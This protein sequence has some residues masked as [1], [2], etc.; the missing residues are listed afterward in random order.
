MGQSAVASGVKFRPG[1]SGEKVA[2]GLVWRF[3]IFDCV[4]DNLA[5]FE[6]SF[7]NSGSFLDVGSHR[8][9]VAKPF[10]E[11]V[12]NVFDSLCEGGSSCGES[13]NLGT[14]VEVMALGE[15]EG[16]DLPCPERP[17]LERLPPQEQ[18][19]PLPER[20]APDVSVVDLRAPLGR[21]IDPA[22]VAEALERTRLVLL[23]KVA[24]DE[25]N[26]CRTSTTLSEFYDVHGDAPTELSRDLCRSFATVVPG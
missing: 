5:H 14:M 3:G 26:R 11:E 9:Y 24:E 4:S 22:R 16:G 2:S 18:D 15:D 13:S 12:T 20:D 19:A 6:N 25:A 21:V 10:P 1:P 17:S 23:S 8:F 7:G